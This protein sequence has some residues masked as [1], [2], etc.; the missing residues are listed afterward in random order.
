MTTA[1]A[2][3]A[4]PGHLTR[5]Q[6]AAR[7]GWPEVTLEST[8]RAGAL[9]PSIRRAAG[10]NRPALYDPIDVSLAGAVA[11][12]HRFGWRGERLAEVWR[13]GQR[14]RP[15]LRP[16]WSGWLVLLASGDAQLVTSRSPGPGATSTPLEQLLVEYAHSPALVLPLEV[17][18]ASSAEEAAP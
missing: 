14:K 2:T 12:A 7:L 15:L 9:S 4:P 13:A 17:G 3:V 1:A 5:A 6:L 8:E 16:G 18:S 10:D 11:A